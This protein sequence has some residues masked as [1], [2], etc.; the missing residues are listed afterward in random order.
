MDPRKLKVQELKDQLQ[1]AGLSTAGKKE[2]L[3]ARLLE[4]QK[5]E[6]EV[7]AA[8]ADAGP[9]TGS[10]EGFEWD[11]SKY[12]FQGAPAGKDAE[13]LKAEY[14]KRKN[15][16]ARFGIPLKEQDKAIERAAR[17]GV[18]VTAKATASLAK[19]T[20]SA[21]PSASTALPNKPG[22][23]K[24]QISADVLSKRAE[25]FGI[26]ASTTNTT[27]T[28][29]T[30]TS[31]TTSATKATAGTKHSLYKL[32]EAEEEKKRKRAAKFGAPASN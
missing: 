29:T 9:L 24:A 10:G 21:L 23:I 12:D 19:A 4:H 25:R 8:A 31:K 18:P 22:S 1:L 16:A 28:T 3:V 11:D 2:E 20:D 15:R 6:E 14:E 5:V 7:A 32:D 27:V 13:T 30:T 17:F 26:Q